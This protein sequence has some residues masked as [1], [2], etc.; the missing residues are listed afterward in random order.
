MGKK[1][2]A[3]RNLPDGHVLTREDIAIKSP[4]DGLAPYELDNLVGKVT[5]RALSEDENLA[6][7]DLMD[8]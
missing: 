4:N 3:A 6:F 7:A 5:R 8:A 1:L 2:V